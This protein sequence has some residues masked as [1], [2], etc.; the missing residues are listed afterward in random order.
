MASRSSLQT[1]LEGLLGSTKVYFQPPSTFKMSYPCIVYGISNADTK[2]ANN[3]PYAYKKRYQITVID[4]DPDS[5]IPD[6]V[7]MLPE[8]VFNRHFT[9]ENLN[10]HVFVIWY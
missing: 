9:V 4:A 10:H 2:F 3:K 1:L 8:C 5:A 7:A 6:K